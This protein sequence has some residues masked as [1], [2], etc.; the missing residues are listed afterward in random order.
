MPPR[1]SLCLIAKNEE[2]NLPAC[3]PSVAGLVDEIIVVDTGSTDRTK[4]VATQLGAR[5]F[6][7]TWV[8]S[9]AAARNESVR[10]ATGDWIL[11]L[12]GDESFTEPDRRKFSALRDTLDGQDAAFVM[13]QRSA[14][15]C[16]GGSATEVQQVRLFRN[17]PAIRWSYRVHE[18]ILPGIHRA[19][20]SVRFTDLIVTH[21]GYIDPGLRRRKTERNLRLLHLEEAE[22][23]DDPFTLFNLGWAYLEMGEPERA[24]TRLRRSLERCK[25][26]ESIVRKLYVLI[27]HAHR[28]LRQPRESLAVCRAGRARCPDDFELIFLEGTLLEA[29]GDLAGA[30]ACLR[31]L[32]YLQPAPHFA[33]VDAGLR[34]PKAH[35]HLGR[36]LMRQGRP[37]EAEEHWRAALA[38]LPGMSLARLGLGELYLAQKRW[39]DL[40][41]LLVDLPGDPAWAFDAA[42]LR[43]KACLARQEFAAARQ[44]LEELIRRVP[45]ALMPRLLLTHVLLQEH[46]DLAAAERALREVLVL[47]PREAQ[48]WR[49]LALLLHE[50]G[51]LHEAVAAGRSGLAHCPADGHVLF[52]HAVY[53]GEA[54]DLTGAETCLL[55][56][57]ETQPPARGPGSPERVPPA[58][59]RHHLA[60]V[61][62][63]Q[64]RLGEAE[65][66][67][68]AALA[69]WPDHLPSLLGLAELFLDFQRW[70]DL[71]QLLGRLEASPAGALE[72]PILKARRHL[73]QREFAA[74]RQLLEEAIGCT[75]EAV[76]A[77][78][79]L[80]RVLVEEG[81][82]FA[83]AE[84]LLREVLVL[85][86]GHSQ[87]RKDLTALL[88]RL[89][90]D[91]SRVTPHPQPLSPEGRGEMGVPLS[92]D[93]QGEKDRRRIAF[94]CFTKLPCD[95]DTPHRMPLGGSES[96]LCYLAEALARAG[97]E[98]FL[99]HPSAGS[100]LSRGVRCLPLT[101]Q[102]L[103]L[104]PP[105]DA[106][107]VLNLA[108]QGRTFRPLLPAP[109]QLILWTQHALDQPAVVPLHD[110]AERKAY[111][112]FAFVSDW[113]RRQYVH[114]FD[115]DPDRTAVLRNGISP[116]FQG[117][118]AEGEPI[119]AAKAQPP[120][121]AYT[122]TPYR[123]LD[124][125]LDAFPRIRQAVPGVT[126]KVFSSM[127]VYQVSERED[128]DRFGW[129]YGRCRQLEGVEHVGSR[130]QPEL[131][132]ALR[133]TA[134]LAYPNNYPETSCIAVLEALAAGCLVVTSRR[135][136]LPETAAGFARLVPPDDDRPAYV[137]QF[138]VE[139]VQAL[140]D[141]AGSDPA[142]LEEK[143][144]RQVAHV[145]Q[146]HSWEV[147]AGQWVQ[148]LNRL[149]TSGAAGR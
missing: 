102:A 65:A 9:F 43:A 19:G 90:R 137:A 130:P 112:A 18:Q 35:F 5:V 101:G 131:A 132:A 27:S 54:G 62:M 77:C 44:L 127:C 26:G 110:E 149:R 139:T 22:Q 142:S 76:W 140:T 109:T 93:G 38:E 2:A 99:L 123:G 126:L 125:L 36:V 20:H 96:A 147:L 57:L 106:L 52:Q 86:P 111:H 72:A 87:A 63:Q 141:L 66:Q 69:E 144:G 29:A 58:A 136:A 15:E 28:D 70:S 135:A 67:W 14:P 138:V 51:R 74:A 37:A 31:P 45:Q 23:P 49:N 10:H 115:L 16:A 119:L 64:R 122:S 128:R 12:D 1:I 41:A 118:F 143:L 133:Q 95:V 39:A 145:Q 46:R 148:W 42:V 114:Q 21:T 88:H 30:E 121:L 60:L 120:V 48:S 146:H 80:S 124:L 59:A 78:V 56:F 4:E 32:L 25:P 97:H 11:W 34:G 84:R 83:T 55:R 89:G 108:G 134:V 68:R 33:S 103:P 113:Q 81:Q 71:E 8:D 105:L 129:L 6:D 94:V 104:L 92:P 82:D 79:V 117:L 17:H 53:L 107:V 40:E 116:A 100:E 85:A 3:L 75:P 47:E 7:F 61:Y 24:L 13:T 73:A 98:I 91:G 50:Q